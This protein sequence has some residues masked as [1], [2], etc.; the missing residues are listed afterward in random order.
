[1]LSLPSLLLAPPGMLLPLA[2]A[3]CFALLSMTFV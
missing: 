1:M 2:Q 3:R